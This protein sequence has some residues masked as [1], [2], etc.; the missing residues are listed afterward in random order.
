M[1]LERREFLGHLLKAAVVAV[2]GGAGLLACPLVAQAQAMAQDTGVPLRILNPH[3]EEAYD[4]QLFVGAAWNA[5]ALIACD[6]LMR[7]WRQN[8]LA[9]CDRR[10]YAAL[11]V[12][13]RY[14]SENGRIQ[15]NSG[16]RTKT[17]NELL[18][19]EGLGVAVNSQHLLGHAVDFT[20][21]NVPH[22]NIARAVWNLGL[23]GVGLYPTFVHMDTR[24]ERVNWGE[25]FG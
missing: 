3:T 16:F 17:T 4:I 9:D 2:G 24:G 23:G 22:R 18:R 20:I 1:A 8:K 6:W 12:L 25:S 10:L 15:L 11:Y 7:D 13:Q 5:N 14:F 19:T 21:P